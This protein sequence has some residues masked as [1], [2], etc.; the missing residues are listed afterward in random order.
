MQAVGLDERPGLWRIVTF[1]LRNMVYIF[2][3]YF[4]HTPVWAFASIAL[5]FSGG[6]LFAE[7]NRPATPKRL[8]DLLKQGWTRWAIFVTG[9]ALILVTAACAPVVYAMNAYPDDRTIIVPQFVVVAA[10]MVVSVLLGTGLRQTGWLACLENA[11]FSQR[12][13]AGLLLIILAITGL[14]LWR[15]AVYLADFRAFAQQW[16]EQAALI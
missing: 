14:S 7:G 4:L 1:S 6:W 13:V 16:D 10:V 8:S 2:G 9:T 15:S 12:L 11:S 3:K 5:P